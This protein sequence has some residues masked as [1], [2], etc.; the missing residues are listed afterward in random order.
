MRIEIV[1]GRGFDERDRR[2][3]PPVTIL[4]KRTADKFWPGQDPIGR[5]LWRDSSRNGTPHEVIGVARDVRT[6]GLGRESPYIMYMAAEQEPFGAMSIVLR[7]KSPD[8]TAFV[9]TARQIVASID[10][11][12][13]LSRVQTLNEVVSQ[14]V[15]QPR[16]ISSLTTL[17]ATLAGILA[18]VGVYGV[19]AYNVRR[20]R[21]EFGIRL[22]L[23]ADPGAV[24]RLVVARGLVLGAIGIVLGAGGAWLL[25]GTLRGLLNDVQPND[26]GVFAMTAGLL[27]VVALVAVYL[28]ALQASRTDPMVAL[29]AE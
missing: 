24:R 13:A 16:L 29:R 10:S 2:G 8:P 25:S 26:L 22:A 21:R 20:E 3:G 1:A 17:F 6:F 23:G 9:A 14:S 19:M 15:R 18:A 28:P 11:S 5:R 4:S 27:L 12:L 7:S